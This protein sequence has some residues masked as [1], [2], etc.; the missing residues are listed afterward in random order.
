M[1]CWSWPGPPEQTRCAL[2]PLQLCIRGLQHLEGL[3]QAMMSWVRACSGLD[4]L[5]AVNTHPSL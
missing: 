1:S 5:L 2:L 3:R 4:N